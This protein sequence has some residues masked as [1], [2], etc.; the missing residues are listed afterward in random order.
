M[1]ASV[2]YLIK[3][4]VSS[5]LRAALEQRSFAIV[6]LA[7]CRA[8]GALARCQIVHSMGDAVVT[9]DPLGRVTLLQ[10]GGGGTHRLVWPMHWKSHSRRD[11]HPG[12][13]GA[14]R[15]P[16]PGSA[17]AGNATSFAVQGAFGPS[18]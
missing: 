12:S 6:V 7:H 1:D 9:V 17:Y 8:T 13:D 4:F 10:S 11:G 14:S 3:P 16:A 2:A 18:W 15:R 5:D